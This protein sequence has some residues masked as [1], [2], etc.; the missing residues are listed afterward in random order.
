MILILF[1]YYF[2]II[3]IIGAQINAYYV[4]HYK[5]L[6]D[7]LGTYLSK[8]YGEHTSTIDADH[9]EQNR[10]GCFCRKRQEVEPQV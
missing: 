2:G 6:P 4:E 5:P 9:T 3:L 10:H 1:F 8:L 7:P